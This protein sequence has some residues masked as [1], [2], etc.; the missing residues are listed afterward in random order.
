MNSSGYTSGNE[1]P[2]TLVVL[3]EVM[4]GLGRHMNHI[5]ERAYPETSDDMA[6]KLIRTMVAAMKGLQP[7]DAALN[8]HADIIAMAQSIG[9]QHTKPSPAADHVSIVTNNVYALLKG[10]HIIQSCKLK[11]SA[12]KV[13]QANAQHYKALLEQA[14]QAVGSDP[15]LQDGM[16]VI[17]AAH[18]LAQKPNLAM[19]GDYMYAPGREPPFSDIP[20]VHM[21]E[22]AAMVAGTSRTPSEVQAEMQKRAYYNNIA[23]KH[24]QLADVSRVHSFLMQR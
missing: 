1:I 5:V 8:G 9:I 24:M 19:L 21:S 13:I 15:E 20:P 11:G 16:K 10:G 6:L 14:V 4:Q 3:K 12:H 17:A 23:G 2:N 7:D 22:L 18:D